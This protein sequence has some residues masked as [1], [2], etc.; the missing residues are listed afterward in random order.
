MN[1]KILFLLCLI[2]FISISTVS[3]T[4]D[5]NQTLNVFQSG[6]ESIINDDVGT[7]SELQEQ[8][9][10]AENE[11]AI[12]LD[13]DYAYNESDYSENSINI[14]KNI[15]ING[16]GHIIDGGI[17]Y[18][19]NG[20][21]V[22]LNNI[23][24]M[25]GFG[26]CGGAIYAGSDSLQINGCAFIDNRAVIGGAIFSESNSLQINNCTFINNTALEMGGGAIY[27][28]NSETSI[29]NSSFLN[30]SLSVDYGVGSAICFESYY[31]YDVVISNSVFNN[32]LA[33]EYFSLDSDG[34]AYLTSS[35]GLLDHQIAFIV[36]YDTG[37][38]GYYPN[39]NFTNVSYNEF[40]NQSFIFDENT[41]LNY[42]IDN[43]SVRFE[44]YNDDELLINTTN[45][46]RNGQAR[47]D[48]SNLSVGY[49]LLKAYC[50]MEDSTIIEVRRDSNFTM[51]VDDI[52]LGEDLVIFFDISPEIG[53]YGEVTGT[54]TIWYADTY[55][56]REYDIP[57][58]YVDFNF[59]DKNITIQF[60][61]VGNFIAV[62]DFEGDDTF[63]SKRINQSF[64]V[65]P[66]DHNMTGN[67]TIIMSEGL[68]KN[69]GESK[70]LY[71]ILSDIDSNP[72][73]IGR[74]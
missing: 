68:E 24:F 33:Q 11:S 14:D 57:E 10:N 22:I 53:G 30:N 36:P 48:L 59:K 56:Q 28:L 64:N 49:Y 44:V 50:G 47:I 20:T 58:Y 31:E 23:V 21:N 73:K 52:T 62:L 9:N 39:I 13:R 2:L 34:V 66:A 25:G 29:S 63:Y 5:S 54:C 4:D 67:R 74:S 6:G 38:P 51:S 7:F 69:F 61:Y 43:V 3:A 41:D 37:N 46:T 40:K 15:I 18:V 16:N 42:G 35:D 60:P 32:N 27:I 45:V 12:E 1:K 65:Y 72:L 17:F 55:G 19:G 71:V 70:R 8:I 26:F